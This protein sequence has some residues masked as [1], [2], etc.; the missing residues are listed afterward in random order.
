MSRKGT[1]LVVDDTHASLKLLTELLTIEGYTV[2]SADSGELA[3][4][5]VKRSPPELILLDIRMPDMDGFEV[6]KQLLSSEE[7]KSIP[8]IFLSAVIDVDLRVKGLKDGAVDFIIKPFQKEDL[9]ARVRTHL[10]LYQLRVR[11][12]DQAR[13]ISDINSEL[14]REIDQ[15]SIA[16]DKILQTVSLLDA[17]I[18][19]SDD[20]ILALD[21]TGKI[22]KYNHQFVSMWKIPESI[23]LPN[24][25]FLAIDSVFRLVKDIDQINSHI[26]SENCE[27]DTDG[28]DR[29]ELSDGRIFEWYSKPHKIGGIVSGRVW[30]FRD[31]TKRTMME[32]HIVESLQ[33]KEMLLKEIHHRVKNNMQVISSLLYLQSQ[34][35]KDEYTRHLFN[36]SQN[37]I[38]SISLV[39]EQLYRSNNL[40]LIEYGDYLRKMF[41]S[42]FE[43]YKVDVRQVIMIIDAHQVMISIEKAVPCS[44]IV[45]ELISNSLKYAFPNNQKGEIK[46]GFSLNTADKLYTLDYRD[47]GVGIP[48]HV[49]VVHPATL[50]ISLI[51]GLTKQ[52]KGTVTRIKDNGTH[53][54]IS[55]P[56]ID[57]KRDSL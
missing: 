26:K 22:I 27:S 11:T 52:L 21:K 37:R 8:V 15:R 31:V 9:L 38:R 55:F 10:E 29:I 43:S 44:L 13:K 36:E 6:L 42:L 17:T 34:T 2:R 4:R 28:F 33:E 40:R 32:A 30:N 57:L 41:G 7:S 56:S 3:L 47:D 48:E 53:F 45:N 46:I 35:V 39:H 18:E 54:I 24:Q 5:S 1:I 14:K 20:G 19:S 12:E 23:L 51:Y 25:S 49:D 50:G 16:E